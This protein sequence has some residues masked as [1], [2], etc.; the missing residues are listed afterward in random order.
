MQSPVFYSL[1]SDADILK[2]TDRR[3]FERR[4]IFQL[5]LTIENI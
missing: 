5:V 2:M 3:S 4:E 1:P